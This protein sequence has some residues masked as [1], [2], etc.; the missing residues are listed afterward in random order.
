[1]ASLCVVTDGAYNLFEREV[2]RNSRDFSPTELRASRRRSRTALALFAAAAVLALIQPLAG[3]GFIA[4]ALLLHLRPD[5]ARK[6]RA[7]GALRCTGRRLHVGVGIGGRV[8]CGTGEPAEGSRVVGEQPVWHAARTPCLQ[9]R[10]SRQR[11]RPARLRPAPA[12]L[13]L[14]LNAGGA[15]QTAVRAGKTASPTCSPPTPTA[16][17]ATATSSTSRSTRYSSP[18]H[19]LVRARPWKASGVRD[20]AIT[21]KPAVTRTARRPLD[22]GGRRPLYVR[23]FPA[24]PADGPKITPN[25]GQPGSPID[26]RLASSAP[27]IRT[28][29]GYPAWPTAGPQTV[30][31][32]LAP[33]RRSRCH[34]PMTPALTC[35]NSVAGVGFEPT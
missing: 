2:L 35:G 27:D 3:M 25:A 30:R 26:R 33:A 24:R 21:R 28:I 19:D 13:S 5:A 16:S 14:W 7:D 15:P 34:P 11:A 31:E 32:P 22:D 12:A 4:L 20:R 1:M 9:L 17:A 18:P 29:A 6:A 8:G 23:D 10:T